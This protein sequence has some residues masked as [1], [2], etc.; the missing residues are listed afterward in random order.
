MLTSVSI[1]QRAAAALSE[2]GGAPAA[3]RAAI[4]PMVREP[5]VSAT[6]ISQALSGH[7]LG[8]LERDGEWCRVRGGD[9]YEGWVHS[10]YLAP[11]EVAPG[12][13]ALLSLGARVN[14][15]YGARE[16]PLGALLLPGEEPVA[17]DV[18]TEQERARRFPPTVS[19]ILASARTHF[20]GASYQWG[21]VTPWG[22]DCSGFVQTL[23]ALHGL[24][25]PRDAWQQALEGRGVGDDAGVHGA[26]AGDLLFFSDREDGRITHVALAAGG[27]SIM[28]VALGRGGLA[29]DRLDGDEPYLVRLRAQLRATRRV[30][31]N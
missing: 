21:G 4:A 27:G 13:G 15:P 12:E 17:G 6:Q 26:G 28:H 1:I 18:V 30:L 31:T 7:V 3:V 2:P 14:G 24:A 23:L 5:R 11:P 10:G 29:H 9:G 19:A 8:V 20:S 25:L 16:L 22:C